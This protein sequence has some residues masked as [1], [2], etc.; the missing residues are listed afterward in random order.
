[1]GGKRATPTKRRMYNPQNMA[2]QQG[3][4]KTAAPERFNW[5][6]A[7]P[8]KSLEDFRMFV[9]GEAQEA[10]SWYWR[11]KNSKKFP[12]QAVQFLAL[13]LTASAGLVPVA[14]QIFKSSDSHYDSG[15]I[16]SLLVGLAAALLGLDK[17]FGYSTGWIRYTLT[18]TSMSKLLQEFRT[19]WVALSAASPL[20]LTPEQKQ[21]ALLQ[22]VKDFVSSIQASVLEETKQWAADFQNNMAQMEK[23]LK[24]QLDALKDQ[25]DKVAKER[26]EASRVG[27]IELTVTNADQTDGFHFDIALE[28]R[29]GKLSESVSN[30]KVW[31]KINTVQGQ[32]K[33]TINAKAKGNPVSISTILDVKPGDT[34]K[35][36]VTLPIT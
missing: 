14:I 36:A 2:D 34:A 21:A 9:E 27:A 3:D 22:R 30:S 5:N 11:S 1:M 16:A 24:S 7:D 25:V 15:P 28:T 26:E 35:P 18:A 23:D 33:V 20:A 19:D 12:S 4:I 8:A 31:T 13:V 32:C 10:I 6:N 17:A 29:T